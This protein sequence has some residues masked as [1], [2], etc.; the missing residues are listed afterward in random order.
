VASCEDTQLPFA[1][2]DAEW[3][4]ALPG[5]SADDGDDGRRDGER[6]LALSHC[7][8]VITTSDTES[9][10]DFLAT[11]WDPLVAEWKLSPTADD[12]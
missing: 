9:E 1:G 7:Y 12:E 4:Q 8:T 6:P 11:H 10:A 5:A 3:A 2:R